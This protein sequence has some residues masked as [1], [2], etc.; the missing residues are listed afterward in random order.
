MDINLI[1]FGLE[2]KQSPIHRWGVFTTQNIKKNQTILQCVCIVIPK[3][4]YCPTSFLPYVFSHSGDLFIVVG[5]ASLI[6]SSD[7]PNVMLDYNQKEKILNI[8]S[9]KDIDPLEE[10]TLKYI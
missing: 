9:L 4:E 8:I 5:I 3:G 7:A 1:N 2:V 10:I 6:N